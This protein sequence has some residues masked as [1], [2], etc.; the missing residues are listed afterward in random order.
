MKQLPA[1]FCTRMKALLSEEEYDAFL[2]SFE[3]PTVRGLRLNLHKLMELEESADPEAINYAKLVSDW[4]L[5]PM[6]ESSRI[7]FH[8]KTMYA[9]FY[10]DDSC[11]STIGIRP[12]KHPYHEAGL[13]YIQGPEAMQVVQHMQIRPF[14]RVIDLCA[15]PGGKSTQAADLLSADVGGFLISNEYVALRARTLSSNIERMGLRNAAVLNED[16]GKIADHFPEFF[17]RVLVDA[18]CSGEG[19]FRKDETAIA[20]WSPENVRMCAERQREI[21]ANAYRMLAPGGILAYSTCTFEKE[22]DEDIRDYLLTSFPELTLLY[23]K[24]VWPHREP[25]E[26]HYMAIFRKAGSDPLAALE[27]QYGTFISG[28]DRPFE[29]KDYRKQQVKDQGYLVPSI[30]PELRGLRCL[31]A[32]I[33]SET[34]L[35]NRTEPA[36]A[37]SHVLNPADVAGLRQFDLERCS[38]PATDPRI[39]QYLRGLQISAPEGVSGKGWCIVCADGVALG[40]GKLVNGQVKNHFPKGLRFV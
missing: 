6:P 25:G 20:E 18:P 35:K 23:E 28:P 34:S 4:H 31:R 27:A 14:D 26:G 3:K 40:L 19:M 32:G 33:Q 29:E 5:V 1:E 12:G 16:T 9:S 2:E 17:T 24:R 10:L 36:H 13:Y 38:Y 39:D 37:L 22:E 11:L 8:G 7:S 30:L 21:T 15:S